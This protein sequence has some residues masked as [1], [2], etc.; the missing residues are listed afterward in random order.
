[1]WPL[2]GNLTVI[3]GAIGIQMLINSREFPS[4][5]GTSQQSQSQNPGQLVWANA[6]QRAAQQTPIQRQQPPPTSQP[7][8]RVSQ[9]P[10]YPQQQ[11]SQLSHDDLFPSGSQ[12]ANRLDD[13][14]NGGQGL[15]SQLGA[16]GQPQ[17]G[18]IEEF[19]PLGRNAPAELGQDRRSSLLQNAGFG[20]YGAG[21][22]FTGMNQAQGAPNN[23]VMA[24]SMNGQDTAR[25]MSPAAA[26][27]GGVATSRSPVNQGN[28]MLGQEKDVIISVY[29][30]LERILTGFTGCQH[31]HDVGSA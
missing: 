6:S 10:S 28:G 16:G 30:S 18:N 14:R 3:S 1:V 19:P 7:P 5:S 17:T 12:F 25:M 9:T 11:Q 29:A 26:G 15:G 31:C 8:S 4:L 22:G 24:A 13:F 23:N 20:N 27:A 21:I 2:F